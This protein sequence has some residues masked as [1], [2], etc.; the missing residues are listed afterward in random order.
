MSTI[1]DSGCRTVLA[2]VAH[3]RLAR[4]TTILFV[5]Q[6]YGILSTYTIRRDRRK[7]MRVLSSTGCEGTTKASRRR[8]SGCI[9]IR[10][11]ETF[12]EAPQPDPCVLGTTDVGMIAPGGTTYRRGG[13]GPCGTC[14]CDSQCCSCCTLTMPDTR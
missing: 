1:T 2:V 10:L 11:V 3:I 13:G 6:K 4:S 5:Q 8:S 12:V 7:T 14:A 9:Q